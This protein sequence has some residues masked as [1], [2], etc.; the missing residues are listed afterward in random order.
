MGDLTGQLSGTGPQDEDLIWLQNWYLAQ[1]DDEWEHEFGVSIG[2]LDN[3]GWRLKVDLRETSL[4]GLGRQFERLKTERSEH[5][6]FHLWVDQDVFHG[7]GGPL[8]LVDLLRGF[9]TFANGHD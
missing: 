1:C 3:P 4:Q 2:T 6:W 9:R 7:A 5:D 8:N